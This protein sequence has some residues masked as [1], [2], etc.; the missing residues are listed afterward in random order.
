M[1][2]SLGP[3][4]RYIQNFRKIERKVLVKETV[5]FEIPLIDQ[6]WFD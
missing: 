3:A 1:Y 2:R 6:D 5:R 4:Y